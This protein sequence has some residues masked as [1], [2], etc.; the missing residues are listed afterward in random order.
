MGFVQ[1]RKNGFTLM[2]ILV[3]VSLIAILSTLGI[4]NWKNVVDR[5]KRTAVLDEIKEYGIQSGIARGDT[6]NFWRLQDLQSSTMPH[7][8]VYSRPINDPSNPN[9]ITV[10]STL[11]KGPYVSLQK[12][13]GP[14]NKSKIDSL[15]YPIDL[16]GNR[17]QVALLRVQSG[18]TTL[19][20]DPN[21][22]PAMSPDVAMIISWGRDNTPGNANDG[23]PSAQKVANYWLYYNEAS[24]DDVY[25]FF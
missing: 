20:N 2:E 9:S 6:G 13:P 11:W 4:L 24:S 23:I 7:I 19:M 3:V 5:G 1:K 22:S 12:T 17:Y 14:D 25:Y 10:D 18:V 16:F 15:G 21:I 8:D